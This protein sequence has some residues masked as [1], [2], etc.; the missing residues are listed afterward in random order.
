[1]T[2]STTPV[3]RAQGMRNA[4]DPVLAL[5]PDFL[6][7]QR[8]ANDMAHAMVRAVRTYSDGEAALTAAGTQTDG[9]PT[10]ESAREER[11]LDA[12]MKEVYVCGSG[13]LAQRCDAACVART[14]RQIL[15]EFGEAAPDAPGQ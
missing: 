1:M 5:G 6:S 14:I 11:E 9:A 7:G 12:V 8:E 13:Y 10:T 15:G 3:D 4:L 2:G